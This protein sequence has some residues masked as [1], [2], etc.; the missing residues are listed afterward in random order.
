[1]QAEPGKRKILF[2]CTHNS[3]RSQ[4]A[5][6]LI[7]SLYGDRY[8]AYSAGTTATSVDPRAIKVMAEIGIDISGQRSKNINELKGEYFDV[9]VTVCDRAKALCP[10]CSTGIERPLNVPGAREVIH[11][12]FED[13]AL[14]KGTDEEQLA[15]F[16][17]ARDEIRGWIIQAFGGNAKTE[18]HFCKHSSR[19]CFLNNE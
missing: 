11:R 3:A 15:A 13:P 4:M 2:L 19:I 12:S 1:M 9:A 10:F 18:E 6:G 7:R 14:A 17:F 5:E 8:D 16:R